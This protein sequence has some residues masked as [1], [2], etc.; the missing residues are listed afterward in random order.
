MKKVFLCSLFLGFSFF[1]QAQSFEIEKLR[2]QIQ[3]YTKQDTV[4][5]NLLTEICNQTPRI[6]FE[7]VDKYATE[8]LALSRKLGYEVGEAYALLHQ[9]RVKY[10]KDQNT[11]VEDLL[12]QVDG[13]AKKTGDMTLQYWVYRRFGG[14]YGKKEYRQPISWLLKAEEL[15]KQLNKKEL[16]IGSQNSLSSLYMILGDYTKAMDYALSALKISDDLNEPEYKY[17]TWYILSEIYVLIGEYEKANDY[18]QK[19]PDLH[20]ELGFDNSELANLYNGLGE[21][22]RLSSKLPEAKE[23]YT[24]GLSYASSATDSVVLLSNLADV[25]IRM[26]NLPMAFQYGYES[27]FMAKILNQKTIYGWIYGILARG[28]L[29]ESSPDSALYYAKMGYQLGE[30][31]GI[32]EDLRDNAQ[33]LS[34]AFALKNDFKN[35][36][37]FYKSHISYRDSMMNAEVK[38]RSTVLE[39]NYEMEIKE[40]EITLLTEQRKLQRN[41]LV[42]ALIVL[43]LILIAAFLLVRNIRQKQKANRLLKQ[44]KLEIDEKA[45]ELSIQKDH[46]EKSYD[47]VELLGEIGRKI[48]SSLS[49]DNIIGTVYKNVNG[50]MDAAVFGI[51]I[52]HE[53]NKSLDFPATYENGEALPPYCNAINDKDKLAAICFNSGNEI[54][55]S[56]LEEDYGNFLQSMPTPMEGK[57]P[58]S[59]IYLPL[60]VKDKMFGVITVQSFSKNA[61]SDYHLYMLRTIGLYSAI[62]LENAE[63]FNKLTITVNT[64]QETQKQ[65]IQSEKMASLGE[66]TA[67]IAHEIQNPLNFVNNFSEVSKEM[68]SEIQD[69]RSKSQEARDEILINDNLKDIQE[70]LTKIHHHGKRADSIVKGM[71]AHSRSSSGEK[72]P[73][74]INTLADEFLRLSYHGIRAKDKSFNAD[75]ELDLDPNLPKVEVISQDIGRVLLNLINNSFYAVNERSRKDLPGFQNLEGLEHFKPLVTIS[76]KNLG[77]RIEISVKDNGP[78][79]PDAIKEK[80]FQPFFTTKPPGSGTGLGLSL[81]YDIVKAHGGELTVE[82]K[83]GVGSEFSVTL[84]VV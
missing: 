58:N 26:D 37:L 62:A 7:E 56:N 70:N 27:L 77:D 75:F 80:I 9:A 2:K 15:A 29:K 68:I 24:K 12:Q 47:N 1:C 60:K 3:E 74:D 48:T 32:M 84:P 38:N 49:V 78:G 11:S 34:E 61:F 13:T 18:L 8:A 54:A 82:S 76:T 57:R 36:F 66:L 72:M 39:H 43:G 6:E 14:Y 46:L 42:S 59:L 50:L 20:R 44:Q 73:T 83:G 52:Y 69:E 63:S 30:E 79:I 55:I 40:D 65:L 53:K 35:A 31:I 64:L 23:A 41:F 5:V 16:L 51:G 4:R 19:L 10:D 25:Y 67:G 45:K 22:Y 28:H 81:S 71:L 33:S 17:T 21:N